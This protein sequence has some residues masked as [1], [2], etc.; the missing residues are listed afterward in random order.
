MHNTELGHRAAFKRYIL[1]KYKTHILKIILMITQPL[2]I[3][4][5]ETYCK[6]NH[7]IKGKKISQKGC[8]QPS[9]EAMSAAHESDSEGSRSATPPTPASEL[10]VPYVLAVLKLQPEFSCP[11]IAGI[12]GPAA[13]TSSAV[14]SLDELDVNARA[15][16]VVDSNS[17]EPISESNRLLSRSIVS[18]T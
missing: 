16:G 3:L 10:E 18:S 17:E 15:K 6:H 11:F 4:Y 1:V 2:V 14:S 8:Y 7:T 5:S 9:A 12:D 13:V